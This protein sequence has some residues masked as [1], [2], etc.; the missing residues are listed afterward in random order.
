MKR[1]SSASVDLVVSLISLL[2]ASLAAFWLA[3]TARGAELPPS[4]DPALRERVVSAI[5]STQCARCK[6]APADPGPIADALLA[7]T[8]NPRSLAF[9]IALG[10]HESH[11]RQRLVDNQCKPWECDHGLAWGAWQVHKFK[12]NEKTWGSPN[13]ADQA[14]AVFHEFLRQRSRCAHY[15]GV[16]Q[17][18]A[19]FRAFTG[20][21]CDAVLP[22]EAD[23]AVTYARVLARL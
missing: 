18:I 8:N 20:R 14:K 9:L 4:P 12:W 7:L 17:P 23:R 16:T 19:T 15:P 22:G 11:F 1:E 3:G 21:G 13:V 6:D 5:R 10:G 2:L